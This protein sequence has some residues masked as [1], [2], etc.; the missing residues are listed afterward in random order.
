[1][2]KHIVSFSIPER[3]LGRAD[4]E[5]VVKQDGAILGTLEVSNGSIVWFPKGTSYG[6]KM[7]WTRFDKHMQAQATRFEKR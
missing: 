7:G 6:Y 3:E 2:A 5:F 4:V 1:M